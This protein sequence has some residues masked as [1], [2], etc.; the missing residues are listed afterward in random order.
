MASVTVSPK[1]QLVIPRR[2]RAELGIAPGEK[3]E[4]IPYDGRIELVPVRKMSDMRGFLRGIDT[5]VDRE[6]DRV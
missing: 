3:M 5:S 6:Q 1:F 2:I 4:V